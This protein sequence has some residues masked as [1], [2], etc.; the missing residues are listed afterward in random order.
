M[1][2]HIIGCECSGIVQ[3]DFEQSYINSSQMYMQ[4]PVEIMIYTLW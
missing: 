1:D 3:W 4:N 2:T